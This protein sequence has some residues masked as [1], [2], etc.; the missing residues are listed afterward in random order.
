MKTS[1]NN[2]ARLRRRVL[3]GIV[4]ALAVWIVSAVIFCEAS[5]RVWRR[6]PPVASEQAAAIRQAAR[7]WE[8]VAT[9]ADDGVELKAWFISP[10]R[11]PRGCVLVLH[12][13][14]T[15]RASGLGMAR[16]L[17]EAGYS[18]LMPD[19]RAHGESGGSIVTFGQRE[20][21]DVLRWAAW[22]RGQSCDKLFG[23]G[24]SMGGVALIEA[25]A[26][27]PAFRS[28]VA[29]CPY[30]DLRTIAEE[31]VVQRLPVHRRVG[32]LI[33]RLLVP[34]AS[35][36]ARWVYGLDVDSPA[37]RESAARLN[38]PLLLIHGLEDTKIPPAHSR[39]IA[40][41]DRRA[42][43]WLVPGAAHVSASIV[44]PAEFSRQVLNWFQAHSDR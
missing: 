24:V 1:P 9:R 19:S 13:A 35:V 28:I 14:T 4:L 31:R 30:S 16:K 18:V 21:T 10:K 5:L 22:A 26:E 41:A 20:R 17:V 7:T 33:A 36:Y 6:F 23:L 34:A 42:R 40:A 3:Y 38:T 29:E 44:Q 8:G 39:A 12:G 2:N 43:L 15:S 25:A 11:E 37:A 32:R 27:Q